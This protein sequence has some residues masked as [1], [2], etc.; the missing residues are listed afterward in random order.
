MKVDLEAGRSTVYPGTCRTIPAEASDQRAM[1]GDAYTVRMDSQKFGRPRF[2]DAVYGEFQK[3]NPEED[4]V[5]MKTDGYPTYHLANVVDD[6]LMKITHVVRGEVS[7]IIRGRVK[8]FANLPRNGS[9]Q[10]QS[11]WLST[12]LLAGIL[13]PLPTCHFLSKKMA[14]SSANATRVSI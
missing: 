11:T 4:F 1:S 6:Y 8:R 14:R 2:V 7:L 5:L 13:R 9:S 12:K 3:K 10:R